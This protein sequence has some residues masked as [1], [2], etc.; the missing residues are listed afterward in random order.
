[1][2]MVD[3]RLRMMTDSDQDTALVVWWR[4]QPD[5]RTLFFN[6]D[7]VTPDTHHLFMA[8]RKPHDLVYM[9]EADGQPV[10][11]CS[12]TVDVKK[13]EAEFGRIY[14]DPE[15][16]GRGYARTAVQRT[17]WYGF[18]ILRLNRIWIEAFDDNRPILAL[19]ESLGLTLIEG[20]SREV[21]GRRT[22]FYEIS[23]ETWRLLNADTSA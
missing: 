10:G 5:A 3:L 20:Q 13:R 23:Y 21:N 9:I 6:T 2:E 16:R 1:M 17:L 14:I 4:N 18:E 22:V 8:T 12:L 19:Y 11:M 7:V 15:Q